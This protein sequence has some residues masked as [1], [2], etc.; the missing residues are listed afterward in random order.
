MV[1]LD[2]RTAS[3]LA[4]VGQLLGVLFGLPDLL[5]FVDFF[6]KSLLDGE[7]GL[8]YFNEF[9]HEFL[10]IIG[11]SL[12]VGAV[13]P[14]LVIFY[15]LVFVEGECTVVDGAI[16]LAVELWEFTISLGFCPG[17]ARVALWDFGIEVRFAMS[18]RSSLLFVLFPTVVEFSSLGFLAKILFVLPSALLGYF[19]GVPLFVPSLPG[20]LLPLAFP[21][22]LHGF[23]LLQLFLLPFQPIRLVLL[24]FGP[25]LL[26]YFPR[27]RHTFL[28]ELFAVVH[29]SFAA[30]QFC[31][32]FLHFL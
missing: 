13:P 21:I 7:A 22:L 26:P 24:H 25:Q 28:D 32:C 9:L 10:E 18:S 20:D 5:G 8:L 4:V 14:F 2:W 17:E 12:L 16:H 31:G 23:V 19:K 11:L 15:V 29:H 6:V 27:L 3:F 30:G 1:L